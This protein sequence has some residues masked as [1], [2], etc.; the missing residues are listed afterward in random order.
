MASQLRAF[1]KSI[2]PMT[3][4]KTILLKETKSENINIMGETRTKHMQ[5]Y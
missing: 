5:D 1:H 3:Q 4:A 2:G